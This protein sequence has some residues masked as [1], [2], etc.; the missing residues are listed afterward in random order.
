MIIWLLSYLCMS[1]L[2]L[3]SY[4][5]LLVYISILDSVH[6]YGFR[7]ILCSIL[8]MLMKFCHVFLMRI[9]I[10]SLLI[11][12]GISLWNS[13]LD[14]M[15]IW[16]RKSESFSCCDYKH[17]SISASRSHIKVWS[18]TL[19]IKKENQYHP[20]VIT[21]APGYRQRNGIG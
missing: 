4:I 15:E 3:I 16:D 14:S 2:H 17:H 19:A 6:I 12:H 1:L 18:E 11:L 9:K 7:A 5:Q 20:P 8:C 21:M 13:L 10:T